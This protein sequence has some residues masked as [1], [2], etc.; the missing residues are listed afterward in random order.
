MKTFILHCSGF[1]GI[2]I[3]SQLETFCGT[4]ILSVAQ[5]AKIY[6]VSLRKEILTRSL[7]SSFTKFIKLNT[8][9][10]A[11]FAKS[12]LSSQI[13]WVAFVIRFRL[14]KGNHLMLFEIWYSILM[15][16]RSSLWQFWNVCTSSC[17]VVTYSLWRPNWQE[18]CFSEN[19]F[20]TKKDLQNSTSLIQICS[21]IQSASYNCH[22]TVSFSICLIIPAA[23]FLLP[24]IQGSN[25]TDFNPSK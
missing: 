5:W 14:G 10:T 12:L 1:F 9:L 16:F 18:T 17:S 21:F 6:P 2:H 4:P 11:W 22:S 20:E 7:A 8:L 23:K 13:C 24:S 25:E 19:L 15:L 3:P